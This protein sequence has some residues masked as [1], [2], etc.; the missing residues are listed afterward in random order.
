MMAERAMGVCSSASTWWTSSGLFW[1]TNFT[2]FGPLGSC[3]LN[4]R[5]S[6]P[7][8]WVKKKLFYTS[9]PSTLLPNS[10]VC[11]EC[12]CKPKVLSGQIKPFFH[13]FSHMLLSDHTQKSVSICLYR[14]FIYTFKFAHVNNRLQTILWPHPQDT[15]VVG[16]LSPLG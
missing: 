5:A 7:P 15:N 14:G 12:P 9:F 6:W 2:H 13:I 1:D 16:Q 4:N 3:P 10:L 11:L 8:P